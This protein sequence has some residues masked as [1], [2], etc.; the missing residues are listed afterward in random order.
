[1]SALPGEQG[2]SFL[3]GDLLQ[4][5]AHERVG[6]GVEET[7]AALRQVG[8]VCRRLGRGRLGLSSHTLA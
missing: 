2:K 7:L 4:A 1:M 5:H 3:R 8:F 6:E